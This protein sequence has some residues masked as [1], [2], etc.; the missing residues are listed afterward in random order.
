[1]DNFASIGE[2]YAGTGLSSPGKSKAQGFGDATDHFKIKKS[3]APQ[4]GSVEAY[5]AA[6][7]NQQQQ[8]SDEDD[9]G[10]YGISNPAAKMR[11]PAM[12]ASL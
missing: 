12:L 4:P 8:N 7:H 5:H 3:G 10:E 11:D 2:D 9:R 6:F 1:M